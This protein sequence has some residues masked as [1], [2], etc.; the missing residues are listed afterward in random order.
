MPTRHHVH[1]TA[2]TFFKSIQKYRAGNGAIIVRDRFDDVLWN[3]HTGQV[4]IAVEVQ[5]PV[6]NT[7]GRVR[8]E[9]NVSISTLASGILRDLV[10]WHR[11][12]VRFGSGV[13]DEAD[14]M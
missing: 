9:T 11:D 6:V 5:R 14:W 7:A 10:L 4:V 3:W 1:D 8:T 12:I 13:S 2:A